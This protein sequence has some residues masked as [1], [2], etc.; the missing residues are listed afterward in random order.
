MGILN[1]NPFLGN[2]CP[3]STETLSIEKLF[4]KR[5][6]ID[7]STMIHAE[8]TIATKIVVSETNLIKTG[9]QIN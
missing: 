7:A 4:S 1:L 6:G 2:F 3:E 9:G 5:V 8:K